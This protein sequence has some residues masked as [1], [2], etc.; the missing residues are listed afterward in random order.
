MKQPS[1]GAIPHQRRLSR[2][3]CLRTLAATTFLTVMGCA[4]RGPSPLILAT[5]L[6]EPAT[7]SLERAFQLAHPE[8][9]PL[10][11]IR[12]LPGFDLRPVASSTPG[13]QLLVSIS[14]A[15][16]ST[17]AGLRRLEP[18]S[19]GQGSPWLLLRRAEVGWALRPDLFEAR[20]LPPAPGWSSAT[21]PRLARFIALGDPRT[22]PAT[23]ALAREHLQK[24][25]SWSGAY[26]DLIRAAA[27]ARPI[28]R[29]S[30]SALAALDH[31]A[32]ALA[33]VV[34]D[35]LPAN[36]R[37]DFQPEGLAPPAGIALISSCPRPDEARSFLR[38]LLEAGLAS[39]PDSSFFV[40]ENPLLAILLGSTLVDAQQELV[41]ASRVLE[42]SAHPARLE[43][44]LTEPPPWPPASISRL[45]RQE[46]AEGE[47]LRDQL[48]AQI[49]PDLDTRYWLLESWN[50][51]AATLD[52]E[53]LDRLARAV[54][55]KLASEPRF[56][57]WLQAEWT[58][59]A[60]QRYR[61][62]A[63]QALS[64]QQVPQEAS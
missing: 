53:A 4:N 15:P 17:M 11:W 14:L 58:S 3:R 57:A 25:P 38:F 50:E 52:G 41:H 21:D 32:V 60:R 6:P 55:G 22:D 19:A 2:R 35:K 45:S 62:V 29:A 12:P 28:R 33:P 49:A 9:S 42:Q 56:R 64:P 59:W 36:L 24:Q 54:D 37:V 39:E 44:F 47:R 51:T 13:V 10:S 46:D 30:T 1:F 26:A 16:L 8:S 7:L 23:L 31:G 34:S 63:R 43:R 20:A 48:A 61:R 5:D 18:L 40:E 27:L